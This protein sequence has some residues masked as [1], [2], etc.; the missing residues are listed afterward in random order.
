MR[1]RDFLKLLPPAA[2]IPAL[3]AEGRLDPVRVEHVPSPPLKPGDDIA[4]IAEMLKQLY[5]PW[6]RRQIN[7]IPDL[8]KLGPNSMDGPFIQ[9]FR[10]D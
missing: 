10:E 8:R 4:M 6:L 5:L 2:A 3:I 9:L 1:R 7:M